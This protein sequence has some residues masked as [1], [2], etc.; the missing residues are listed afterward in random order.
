M[1]APAHLVSRPHPATRDSASGRYVDNTILAG[2][3]SKNPKFE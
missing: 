1:Y 2:V 3:I